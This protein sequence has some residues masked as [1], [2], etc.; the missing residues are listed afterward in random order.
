M[1]KSE[2]KK[3]IDKCKVIIR[4]KKTNLYGKRCQFCGSIKQVG[5]FHIL[6][7]GAYPRLEL[8]EDNILLACWFGCHHKWHHDYYYARDVIIP[9]IKK[10]VGENY[11]EEL[12]AI[13]P[14]LPKLSLVRIKEIHEELKESLR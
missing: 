9:K 14:T 12:K 5:L 13:Y 1:S 10:L 8:Y 7:V 2:R 6:S 3:W 4:E 11:E